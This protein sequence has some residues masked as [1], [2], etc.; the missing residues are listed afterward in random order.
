MLLANH[1]SALEQRHETALLDKNVEAQQLYKRIAQA[2]NLPTLAIMGS[3]VWSDVGSTRGIRFNAL[4]MLRIPISAFWT[5]KHEV[6]VKKIAVQQAKDLR[7]EK[8]QMMLLQM[9]DAFDKLTNAYEEIQLSQK[10]I[11]KANENL[12]MNEDYYSVG[13]INMTNLLDAQRLQ[14]QAL[15]QYNDAVCEYQ[16]CRS[17]YLIVTAR[18][19]QSR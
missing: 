9:Q 4:A 7:D 14:Q 1:L 3:A 15:D 2:D 19:E 13:T 8:R 6:K 18:S 12:R 5:N 16:M 11:E 10:A 17:H